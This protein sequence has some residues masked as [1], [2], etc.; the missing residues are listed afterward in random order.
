MTAG[1]NMRKLSL[2][3][4]LIVGLIAVAIPVC[5]MIGCTMSSG[6]MPFSSMPMF[7]GACDGTTMTNTAPVGTLPPNAQS[8]ILALAALLGAA[9]MVLSPPAVSS[10]M[11]VVAED[12]P[13]P[14][15]DPRGVRLIL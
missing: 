3:M 1:L 13:D 7:G 14:P 5:Q 4:V 10:R 6:M 8:M 9:I 12:P 15:E 11:L 2:T